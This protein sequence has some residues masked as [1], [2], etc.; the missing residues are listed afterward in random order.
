MKAINLEQLPQEC[1]I[2]ARARMTLLCGLPLEFFDDRAIIYMKLDR[3]DS[4]G[5][6]K[7]RFDIFLSA[8]SG[9]T[10]RITRKNLIMTESM[11]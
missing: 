3:Y 7:N 11:R 10:K 4:L 1:L 9:I 6:C 5:G 8:S 2:Y